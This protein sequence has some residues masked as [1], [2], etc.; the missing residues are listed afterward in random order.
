[1]VVRSVASCG[2]LGRCEILS[3]ALEQH[4]PLVSW[5]P[6][7]GLGRGAVIAAPEYKN[8][9]RPFAD[10]PL[11]KDLQC[12]PATSLVEVSPANVVLSTMRLLPPVKAG[13]PSPME[14]RL[15][16]TA[17][18]ATDVVI[19]LHRPATTVVETNFLGEPIPNAGKV[20]IVGNELRFHI[21]PWKI[22]TLRVIER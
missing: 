11:P 19:R 7:N 9:D 4:V 20:E 22:V 15:Y 5:S 21:E 3:H 1:V 17:G 6:T 10:T 8:P 13:D 12:G 16:E 18:K 2:K 14:L